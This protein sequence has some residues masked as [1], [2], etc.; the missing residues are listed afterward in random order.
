MYKEF[1]IIDFMSKLASDSS[2]PG[3][4]SVAALVGAA[5]CGLISM[6]ASLTIGKKGYEENQEL[7]RKLID[8]LALKREEFLNA[9]DEDPE[10]YRKVIECYRLP[11]NTDEEKAR[12]SEAIQMA[13]IEATKV[14]LAI[15]ERA[16]DLF[17]YAEKV[18]EKGNKSAASDGAVGA[19]MA[20]GCILAA[21]YGVR[22][23]VKSIK[24]ESLSK[25]FLDKA[26]EL[27]ELA[28]TREAEVRALLPY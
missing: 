10:S 20:R 28:I 26:A 2:S 12:R 22:T 21:I 14:P 27:E 7:M 9:I 16:T 25:E 17:D 8:E 5:A 6:V 23:N 18:I 15:A 4:G 3:G 13:L 24:D 1:T 11:N 19:L